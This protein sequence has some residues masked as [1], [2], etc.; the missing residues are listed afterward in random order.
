MKDWSYRGKETKQ[1]ESALQKYTRSKY[2]VCTNTGTSALYISYLLSGIQE[3]DIVLV[4]AFSFIATANT[5]SYLK[6]KIIFYD[7]IYLPDFNMLVDTYKPKAIIA[8]HILGTIARGFDDIIN[9][10]KKD[11][12]VLIEDSC[13]VLGSWYNNQHLGTFGLFGAL[14]FN[15]NKIITTGGGGAILTQSK[16]LAEKA[17]HLT[18]VAKCQDGTYDQIGFNYAMPSWNAKLGL[19]QIKKIE[20]IKKQ[21]YKNSLDKKQL[22]DKDYN[23]WLS[24]EHY[25]FKGSRK[26]WSLIPD[27][28]IYKDCEHGQLDNLRFYVKSLWIREN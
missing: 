25:Q 28:P 14:S 6:A 23:Y 9:R 18:T 24:A 26:A 22:F 7:N 10:C 15:G 12:I 1:F 20:K 11:N 4:P 19:K 16:E 8:V 27:M 5:V 17:R 3:N 2:I 21:K 13:Q